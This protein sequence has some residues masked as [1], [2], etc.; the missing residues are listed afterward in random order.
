M[1]KLEAFL[2]SGSML[3]PIGPVAGAQTDVCKAMVTDAAHS[4]SLNTA[5]SSYFVSIYNNYCYADGSTNQAAVNATGSA[6]V[7][8][9][10]LTA[11][12]AGTD[13]MSKFMN[14]CKNYQSIA[15]GTSNSLVY[16]SAVV[17]KSLEAANECLSIVTGHGMSLSY[18]VST[19]TTLL[20]NIT[21]PGGQTMVVQGI[22]ADTGVACIGPDLA[23]PGQ[24]ITYNTGT[25]QTLPGGSTT[26]TCNRQPFSTA[27][28]QTMYAAASVAVSSSVGPLNIYWPQDSAFPLLTASQIQSSLNAVT[29]QVQQLQTATSFDNL[30]IGTLLPWVGGGAPPAGW[31]L[32]DGSSPQCPNYSDL[33]LRGSGQTAVGGIAGSDSHSHGGGAYAPGTTNKSPTGNGFNSGGTNYGVY[34]YSASNVPRYV[35]VRYIM[36]VSMN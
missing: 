29:A 20:I 32:C 12:F 7:D 24:T 6:I 1:K 18:Q 5:D 25:G 17:G 34:V 10:P 35:A 36:K 9:I 21:V 30:P 26:I 4:V 23:H 14:F 8:A 15:A 13:N 33:F 27:G 31:V 28:G 3:L 19:P 11:G 16:Q 2:L 22:S